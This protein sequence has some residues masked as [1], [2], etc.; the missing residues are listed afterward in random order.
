MSTDTNVPAAA[1][2]EAPAPTS[3]RA[4]LAAAAAK[5]T[6]K[7]TTA[8]RT[9]TRKPVA[10]NAAAAKRGKYAPR[11][12]G[13]IRTGAALLSTTRPVHAAIID[14]QAE[15]FAEALDEVAAEDARVAAFLDKV[16]GALGKGGAW[17]K[18]AAVTA[19]TAGALMLA[20]GTVPAGPAGMALAFLAG[21]VVNGAALD[22]AEK[23]ARR[24]H[25]AG[26]PPPTPERVA[27]IAAGLL[28]PPP[29][30]PAGDELGDE[31][32]AGVPTVEERDNRPAW[33]L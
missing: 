19:S 23:I 24:E 18:L 30:A 32:G 2:D 8:K 20:S 27:A 6:S 10:R 16:S 28:A 17:G 22:A 25:E 3:A 21:E 26:G 11:V 9:S 4:R 13:A 33:A 1:V 15:A 29:P 31:L 7:S 14:R 5:R 12:V